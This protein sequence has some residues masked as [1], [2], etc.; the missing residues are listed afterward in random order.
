MSGLNNSSEETSSPKTREFKR[1]IQVTNKDQYK[2]KKILGLGVHSPFPRCRGKANTC[3]LTA[4]LGTRGDFYGLGEHTGHYGVGLCWRHEKY[5]G[6][7]KALKIARTHMEAL[8][9][10]GVHNLDGKSFD[11]LAKAEAQEVEQYN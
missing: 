10:F 5:K 9:A 11:R 6:A 3:K 2:I 8:Q 1:K 7:E 4:G